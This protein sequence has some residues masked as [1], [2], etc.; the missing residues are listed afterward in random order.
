MFQPNSSH[1]QQPSRLQRQHSG[2]KLW[3]TL[4]LCCW[5]QQPAQQ[6][7]EKLFSMNRQLRVL[8]QIYL[9]CCSQVQVETVKTLISRQICL[10]KIICVSMCASP[11]SS[12]WKKDVSILFSLLGL[13]VQ[14]NM[15]QYTTL[16]TRSIP[17]CHADPWKCVKSPL[18]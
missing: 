12:I 14:I 18:H 5:G 11:S 3:T 9:T 16:Y 7:T 2:T 4:C 6:C 15:M 8:G 10:L 17:G 13:N 1:T